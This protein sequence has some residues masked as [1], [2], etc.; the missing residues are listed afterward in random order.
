VDWSDTEACISVRDWGTGIPPSLL[1][2]PGKPVLLGSRQGLGIGL[3]LSHAAVERQGGHIT[4]RNLDQGCEARL[5][6]PRV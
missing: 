1:E 5:I 4:L 3:M 2:D 6:L